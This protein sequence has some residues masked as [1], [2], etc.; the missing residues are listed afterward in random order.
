[1]YCQEHQVIRHLVESSFRRC[2]QLDKKTFQLKMSKK[3]I[4][5]DLLMQIGC[6]VYQYSKLRMFQFYYDFV[7]VFVDRRDFENCAMDT[8]SAYIALSADILEE[9]IKPDLRQV[10]DIEKKNWFHR[11]DT[12][13]HATY[14]KRTPVLFKE[15]HSGDGIIALCSKTYYCFGMEDKFSCK[16]INKRTNQITKDKYMDVL[17]LKKYGSSTNRGFRS[18]DNHVF[19]YFHERSGF[20][21]FYPKTESWQM[22]SLQHH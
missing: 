15:E 2:N 6:F 19:T 12:P 18:M 16:G 9:A 8:D 22:G 5:L 1:M 10:Y 21:Y 4:R 13:E 17:L 11:N 3:T 14:D 7:D 20:S